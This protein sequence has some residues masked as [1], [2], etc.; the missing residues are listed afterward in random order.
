MK[1]QISYL[2]IGLLSI[3]LF[4]ACC[5]KSYKKNLDGIEVKTSAGILK[6]RPYSFGALRV[7]WLAEGE[8]V[9]E[10]VNYAVTLD[11]PVPEFQV[12]ESEQEI[13]LIME[14]FTAVVNKTTGQLKLLS[15]K[16]N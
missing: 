14:Q 1:K 16:N 12:K 9:P 13:H 8:N 5:Q 4:S 2:L 15:S 6:L 10:N 11:F 3:A 7:Q